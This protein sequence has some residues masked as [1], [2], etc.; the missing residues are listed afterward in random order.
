VELAY[1]VGL[2]AT[3]GNLG[4]DRRHL[5]FVSRD[6]DLVETLRGSLRLTAQARAIRTPNGGTLYR[7]Q[8][9]NRI[10]HDW[11]GVIGLM[12][13]KSLRLGALGVPEEYFADFFRGCVDGDGSVL[14]Y[15]D[16]QH[17]GEKADYVYERLYVSPGVRESRVRGVDPENDP[18]ARRG[19]WSSPSPHQARSSTDLD[20]SLTPR[21]APYG[22]FAGCT[23]R[24]AR[25]AS[26]ESAPRP[27]SSLGHSARRRDTQ[28]GDHGPAGYTM[29]RRRVLGRG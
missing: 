15:T 9:S 3:D 2:M 19:C 22:S 17:A 7:V 20:A 25:L 5:S 6:R 24:R 28:S 29:S 4:A 23:I 8:W 10:L 26:Y 1:A 16:Q 14:L 13:A 12:P 11:F 21:P 18:A 27:R